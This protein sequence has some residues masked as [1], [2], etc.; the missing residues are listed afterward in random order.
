MHRFPGQRYYI[1]KSFV[2]WLVFV[3]M[4]HA[5]TVSIGTASE[6]MGTGSGHGGFLW[7]QRRHLVG[8]CMGGEALGWE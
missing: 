5:S 7:P 2:S 4:A 6:G 1:E 3:D 8:N